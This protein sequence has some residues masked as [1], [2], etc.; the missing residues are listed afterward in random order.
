MGSDERV[1][2]AE[3]IRRVEGHLHLLFAAIPVVMLVL[4]F[5]GFN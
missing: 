2:T 1:G 3:I 5:P 4:A